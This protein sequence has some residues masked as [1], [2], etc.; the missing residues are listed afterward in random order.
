MTWGG[1]W[2]YLQVFAPL[3]GIDDALGIAGER[4]WRLVAVLGWPTSKGEPEYQLFFRR[5]PNN[6]PGE[7][8][9]GFEPIRKIERK[10][11]VG[12]P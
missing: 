2:E 8:P 5:L 11:L 12:S 1:Q 10:P 6:T 4:C 3:S 7:D 9:P